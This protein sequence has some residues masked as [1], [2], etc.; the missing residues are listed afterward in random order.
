MVPVELHQRSA[1]AVQLGA[2]LAPPN[3]LVADA[4]EV[5]ALG[6]TSVPGLFAAGDASG[7]MPSV[8]VAIASGSTAAATIVRR[9]VPGVAA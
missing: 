3:P 6:H 1:L 8:A 7:S 9:L 4:V 2:A 5:D